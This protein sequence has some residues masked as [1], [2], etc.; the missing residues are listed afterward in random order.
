M[1]NQLLSRTIVQQTDGYSSDKE[2]ATYPI[3]NG[4]SEGMKL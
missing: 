3:N 4:F 1:E 2:V